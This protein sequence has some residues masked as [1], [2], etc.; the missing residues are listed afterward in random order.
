MFK[1][2]Q[3]IKGMVPKKLLNKRVNRIKNKEMKNL[4]KNDI[5]R[6]LENSFF[7]DD[8]TFNQVQARLTKEYHSIEKGL[9]YEDLRLGFGKQVI[10]NLLDLLTIYNKKN[11]PLNDQSYVNA[12]GSLEEYIKV[13]EAADYDVSEL[14]RII[15]TF[16]TD[17]YCQYNAGVKLITKDSIFAD[18]EGGFEEF[19]NSRHSVRT[20]SGEPVNIELIKK[21]IGIAENTPSACN[22]QPWRVRVVEDPKMKKIIQDNQNGNRGFGDYIDKFLIITSD[23]QYYHRFRERNQANIDGGMY[24]MNLLYA[25]HSQHIATIPLS[26]SLNLEQEENLRKTFD[27]NDS[28]NFIMFIGLGNYV[29]TFKVPVSSRR[30][31]KI[32][33]Y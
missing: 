27:I 1:I 10:Q 2:K 9:G 20:Y 19:S 28:E 31:T 13:H 32:M 25:L 8:L 3:F 18:I 4:I 16:P 15:K 24:A 5:R 6:F 22:R 7:T 33:Y 12:L 17:S 26:G 21:A 23:V 11:Y 14:K 29:D 30:K